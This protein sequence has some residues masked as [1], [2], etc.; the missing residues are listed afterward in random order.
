MKD[1]GA[2]LHT[3]R[4]RLRRLT[5]TDLDWTDQLHSD[6]VVMRHVGGTKSRQETTDL[7][8]RHI[9]YYAD[10]PG[11][12]IWVTEK[13]ASGQAI[14]LHLLNHMRGESLIQVGYLLRP[15]YW[16]MGYATEMCRALLQYGFSDLGLAQISAI[17]NPD[18]RPSQ[19]VLLKCGLR[20]QGLRS[21]AAYADQG[22]LTYFECDA[23]SW[24]HHSRQR[25]K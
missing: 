13:I 18:N 10:H 22:P 23:A 17:T 14:G 25:P 3:E 16:Q 1:A 4:L 5:S 2:G 15:P 24:L 19:K 21:F 7:L 11:L 12:G 9:A 6:P 8:A 20:S